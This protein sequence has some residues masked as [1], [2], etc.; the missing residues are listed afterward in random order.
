[1][2]LSDQFLSK[3]SNIKPP[4]GWNGLGE[5]VYKRTYS[6]IKDNGELESWVDTLSRCVEGAQEIGADYTIEEAERL[7]DHMFNLRCL[8]GGR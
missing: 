6:R 2:L 8:F 7:F 3:Y 5:I 1:M 4:F